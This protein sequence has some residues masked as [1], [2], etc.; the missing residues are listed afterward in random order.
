M[1]PARPDWSR[2]LPRPLVI[3]GVMT[4][5]TLADV[6]E[7]V[8]KHLPAERREKDTWQHVASCLTEA[9]RGADTV[10]VAVALQ[11][12]LS[13]QCVGCRPK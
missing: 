8:E 4:L 6:R 7:L 5:K 13:M 12:V 9:A 1:P 10:D 2:A 3:H 11:M